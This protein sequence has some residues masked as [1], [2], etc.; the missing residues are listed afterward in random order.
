MSI[1]LF[2]TTDN[3]QV[4]NGVKDETEMSREREFKGEREVGVTVSTG[5]NRRQEGRDTEVKG[6]EKG[7]YRKD[8]K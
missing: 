6:D 4:K 7:P 8:R 1:L 5:L 2:W 3:G